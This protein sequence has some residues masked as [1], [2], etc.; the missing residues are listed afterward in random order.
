M[1][2]C[3]QGVNSVATSVTTWPGPV[4]GVWLACLLATP[5]VWNCGHLH[6]QV[7]SSRLFENEI[8]PLLVQHCFACHSSDAEPIQGGLRLDLRQGWE[9]GGTRGTAIVPG[10]PGQ[11]LLMRAV[12]YEDGELQMPP[13]GK[14]SAAELDSLN[15]WIRAGAWDPRDTVKGHSVD[16]A[17]GDAKPDSHWAFQAPQH[18][19]LPSI[20]DG[21]RVASRID[22]WIQRQLEREGLNPVGRADRETL[23]RRV[24][25]DLLGLPPSKQEVRDFCQDA[26]PS[27]FAKCVD[28]ML[29]SPHFGERWGR[30]WLDI[31]RFAESVGSTK[32]VVMPHAWRYRD[33][34]IN[35]MNKDKPYD[36]FVQE[37]IA[38]D[39]LP[40]RSREEAVEQL[41]G[42]GFLALG[43]RSLAEQDPKLVHSEEIAEQVDTLGRAFLGLSLSCARCHAHKFAPIPTEE[44]YALAGI[45]QSTET[46]AGFG[47]LG[48]R[49]AT[50]IR[51]DLLHCVDFEAGQQEAFAEDRLQLTKDLQDLT[52]RI[53]ELRRQKRELEDA[54]P[55]DK[56]AL[57]AVFAKLRK[58][59][60]VWAERNS[61]LTSKYQLAMGVREASQSVD[62]QVE[63]GG[64][65]YRLG[66]T[67]VRGFPQAL[68]P[69]E[70]K[71]VLGE[72]DGSG[73]RELALWISA[74]E[75]P[76]FARVAVN[77]MWHQLLGAGIVRT[78][79]DFTFTGE[80]PSHPELLDAL[81]IDFVQ[82]GFS[83]K[84]F[85]RGVVSSR[86]Y[87]RSSEQDAANAAVDP[88]NRS[89]WRMNRRRL[90]LEPLRDAMLMISGRLDGRRPESVLD[91][92]EGGRVPDDKSKLAP[93][94][95][96][97][98][99][100]V[101]L[102]VLRGALPGMY[103]QFDFASPEQVIGRRNVT[104]TPAQAL[105]L[106][107]NSFVKHCS[108]AAAKQLLSSSEEGGD[109]T[110]RVYL[111]T[112]G[113]RPSIS[114]S[115]R[116]A[117][118][119]VEQ[120]AGNRPEEDIWQDVYHARFSSAEFIHRY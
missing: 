118:F 40:S 117:A 28:Q 61:Q 29:A 115:Q 23:L 104:V 45:F 36:Q 69:A 111:E 43:S 41:I 109:R 96:L 60:E 72:S 42:T 55:F 100:T 110:A 21:S 26:S 13:A 56:D 63:I 112:V 107:N 20:A 17:V 1:N 47:R 44:F 19:A 25:F 94:L 51:N 101:Y 91:T 106:M 31:A 24:S 15:R 6:G 108:L 68:Q 90:E 73:R 102:P 85:I 89:L 53:E 46:L 33:Y 57:E 38:G 3:L 66:D 99:R 80:P 4:R 35:S 74:V 93:T 83:I 103:R 97:S 70:K 9:E 34:V 30:H 50:H 37:Q 58:L 78:V 95:E 7:V 52:P 18:T 64:D 65:P 14:L 84:A 75:N 114:E 62:A 105:F 87:Q 86:L 27:A 48:Q 92:L 82:R 88:G 11:S 16:A 98:F 32:N 59:R 12:E 39:L 71:T 8:R 76:L 119:V 2:H 22:L 5:L 54:E 116:V 10:D 67:V 120:L 81:T 49:R 79:D 113:R 77:R